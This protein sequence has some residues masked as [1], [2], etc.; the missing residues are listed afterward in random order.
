MPEAFAGLMIYLSFPIGILG[1]IVGGVSTSALSGFFNLTYRPFWDVV[2]IWIAATALGYIQ[3]FI[4][5]P[6]I[7]K[8][9]RARSS[10]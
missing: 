6:L 7:W 5:V 1:V 3:W 2:P 9:L 4:A 8:K 10:N